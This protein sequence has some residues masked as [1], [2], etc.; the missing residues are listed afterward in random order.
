MS[1]EVETREM[2]EEE[3]KL[4]QKALEKKEKKKEIL[5]NKIPEDQI[6]KIIE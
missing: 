1:D 3:K 4:I 2:S 6:F 5:L